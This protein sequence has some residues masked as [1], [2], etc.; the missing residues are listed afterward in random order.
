MLAEIRTSSLIACPA[1]S[2]SISGRLDEVKAAVSAVMAL[3]ACA[4]ATPKRIT[5]K[6]EFL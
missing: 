4:E 5:S 3:P 6:E 2:M 1:V